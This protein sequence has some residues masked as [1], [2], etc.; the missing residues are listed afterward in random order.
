MADDICRDIQAEARIHASTRGAFG[1]FARNRDFF[2]G[3]RVEPQTVDR[4]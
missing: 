3:V 1:T 2:N 4:R